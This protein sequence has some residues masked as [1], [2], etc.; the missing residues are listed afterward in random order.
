MTGAPVAAVDCGTN[1]TRLIVVDPSGT[2]LERIMEVTRLG[3][4]VDATRRL[5]HAAVER[6]V[7]VL[8]RYRQV[9]ERHQVGRLRVVATSAVRDA[10]NADTFLDQAEAVLGARPE[11]LLGA[12]EARLSFAGATAQLPAWWAPSAPTLVVDIG[13]GSTEVAVGSA[14]ARGPT[15]LVGRASA[16]GAADA[17]LPTSRAADAGLPTS[18]TAVAGMPTSRAAV[19]GL[20]T[21]RA[22][23]GAGAG[24][25]SHL[26]TR[27]LAAVSVDV[28]CVRVT[29]RLL[30]SDPPSIAQLYR[31]RQE[32]HR[33]LAETCG[34]LP[35]PSDDG[36]MVGLAG[37]V[38]TVA[39]LV[40]GVRR[41]ERRLVHHSVVTADQVEEWL[42]RLAGEPAAQRRAETGM[43][44]GRHDVIV[45]GVLVLAEVMA[46]FGRTRCLVS[47][48]DI[49]DGLAASLRQQ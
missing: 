18:G 14:P 41:Y 3:Q 4:Q 13:G 1:S 33:A 15:P 36:W 27:P 16:A 39:M 42:H 6:T 11:V 47:E 22:G 19:A 48:D 45:A 25:G 40:H 43:V 34:G 21:S 35:S 29:E 32:V 8:R 2:V 9:M 37:T 20:P 12:E 44:E 5:D 46:Y 7:A 26:E 31:A 23:S 49:L 38:A 24:V 30:V 28:G 17:G 10:T